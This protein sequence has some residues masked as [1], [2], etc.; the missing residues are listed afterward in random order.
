M[1]NL[2]KVPKMIYKN[3]LKLEGG[4]EAKM[5]GKKQKSWDV[6]S[7]DLVFPQFYSISIRGK[8]KQEY[9]YPVPTQLHYFVKCIPVIYILLSQLK[10]FNNLNDFQSS[11]FA[12]ITDLVRPSRLKARIQLGPSSKASLRTIHHAVWLRWILPLCSVLNSLS[13]VLTFMAEDYCFGGK[14]IIFWEGV[15][16]YWE[17]WAFNLETWTLV[18]VRLWPQSSGFQDPTFLLHRMRTDHLSFHSPLSSR[19]CF[20]RTLPSRRRD[21]KVQDDLLNSVF[22][23]SKTTGWQKVINKYWV[24][25]IRF[26]VGKTICLFCYVISNEQKSNLWDWRNYL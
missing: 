7:A 5:T 11:I 23:S 21:C 9:I 6:I 13:T 4:S 22:P 15:Y 17:A 26:C 16:Y 1:F 19:R 14:I 2:V 18:P 8:K 10:V 3:G 24:K 25:S 20:A 12:N